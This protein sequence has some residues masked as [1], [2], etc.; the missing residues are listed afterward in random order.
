MRGK[1]IKWFKE[2]ELQQVEKEIILEQLKCSLKIDES[3]AA[4]APMMDLCDAEDKRQ[5]HRSSLATP[6]G[7]AEDDNDNPQNADDYS[8]VR[9]QKEIN[10]NIYLRVQEQFKTEKAQIKR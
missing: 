4:E 1:K 6:E 7:N 9:D 3:D 10:M 8:P 2:Q 5:E